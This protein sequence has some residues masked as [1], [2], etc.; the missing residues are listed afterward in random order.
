MQR[1][2]IQFIDSIDSLEFIEYRKVNALTIVFK[3]Y[4][5][6]IEILQ[7]KSRDVDSS[8]DLRLLARVYA[9]TPLGFIVKLQIN[10]SVLQELFYF[11]SSSCNSSKYWVL[12]ISWI[13]LDALIK[14]NQE[15]LLDVLYEWSV[16]S[17]ESQEQNLLVD[18]Q[19]KLGILEKI[20]DIRDDRFMNVLEVLGRQH[21]TQMNR[22]NKEIA[23]VKDVFPD[24]GDVFIKECLEIYDYNVETVIMKILEDD[25]DSRLKDLDRNLAKASIKD[26]NIEEVKVQI[27]AV[28]KKKSKKLFGL[29][30]DS[31]ARIL[32]YQYD[33]YDDEY[34][35]TFDYSDV[36]LNVLSDLQDIDE[37]NPIQVNESRLVGILENNPGFFSSDQKKSEERI[38]FCKETGLSNQQ[39]EGWYSNLERNPRQKENILRKYEWQGNIPLHEENQEQGDGSPVSASERNTASSGRGRGRGHSRKKGHIRK[40]QKGMGGR[41]E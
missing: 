40:L 13:F 11:Y 9:Y 6:T 35:D 32:D 2:L 25:L 12:R 26:S 14:L 37:I 33:S 38:R 29:D 34:D 16:Q 21:S 28:F 19:G 27:T 18:L 7:G 4:I 5:R 15:L 1:E 24:Y 17:Q 22:G 36:K 41:T 3:E 23:R 39:I 31:K 20:T 10:H 8:K 30:D